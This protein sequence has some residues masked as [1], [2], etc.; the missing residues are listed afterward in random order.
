M[1]IT[2]NL[3]ILVGSTKYLYSGDLKPQ[4]H[5][6]FMFVLSWKRMGVNQTS[7]HLLRNFPSMLRFFQ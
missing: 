1:S 6:V 2:I 5:K 4:E 3:N 7:K